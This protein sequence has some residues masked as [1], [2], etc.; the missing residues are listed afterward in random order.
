MGC[1]TVNCFA[2]LLSIND[3]VQTIGFKSGI[4][5]V[6]VGIFGAKGTF[7]CSYC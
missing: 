1:Q 3:I 7:M 4:L 2:K 6:K 5:V